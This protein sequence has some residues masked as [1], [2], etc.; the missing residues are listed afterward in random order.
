M[1]Q[2]QRLLQMLRPPTRGIPVLVAAMLTFASCAGPTILS[3]YLSAHGAAGGIRRAPHAGVDFA[4]RH[5]APAIAAADGIVWVASEPAT[6]TGCGITV[7]I[8]HMEFGRFTSYAHLDRVLVQVNDVVRRGQQIGRV[9][10]TGASA[11]VPHVHFE[12]HT[13]FGMACHPDGYLSDTEDPLKISAGCYDANREYP[14]DKLV[15][16][17]PVQCKN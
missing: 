10:T 3:P 1:F 2:H 13:R 17:H 9:G 16:T 7:V 5:G 14:R 12:L 6:P 4:E 8:A 15:L 11:G